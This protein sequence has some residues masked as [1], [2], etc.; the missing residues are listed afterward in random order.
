MG[1]SDHRFAH[2]T[3]DNDAQCYI[4]YDLYDKFS[5]KVFTKNMHTPVAPPFTN[6]FLDFSLNLMT[7][8]ETVS[9]RYCIMTLNVIPISKPFSIYNNVFMIKATFVARNYS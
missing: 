3:G 7:T 1:F 6:Q 8:L 2:V 5:W 9:F 4:C